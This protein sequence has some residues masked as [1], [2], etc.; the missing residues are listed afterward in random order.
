ML[1]RSFGADARSSA[2]LRH[3]PTLESGRCE[4]GTS[5]LHERTR[6]EHDRLVNSS[7]SPAPIGPRRLVPATLLGRRCLGFLGVGIVGLLAMV[8]SV[9][10]GQEGGDTFADNWWISGPALV[11]ALGLVGAFVT[12]LIAIVR[13]RER[14]LPVILATIVGALVP[15]F[16]IGE[17]TTPH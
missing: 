6:S 8:V 14:S 10:S 15:M 4:K 3:S 9:G 17:I 2:Y 13:N 12:G 11:A 1:D 5:T 16:L 7:T